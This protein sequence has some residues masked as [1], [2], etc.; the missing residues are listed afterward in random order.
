M[1]WMRGLFTRRYPNNYDATT[2]EQWMR[3]IVLRGPMQFQAVRTDDALCISLCTSYPWL[4]NDKEVSVIVI[5]AD[6]G[7]MWQTLPLLRC[8][9]AWAKSRNATL[10]RFSSETPQDCVPLMKRLGVKQDTP[11]FKLEL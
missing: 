1:A 3:E 7:K 10:W 2:T 6:L 8:S 4:P 11:R 5:L 9:I